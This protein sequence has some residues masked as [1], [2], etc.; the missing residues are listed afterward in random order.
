[1]GIQKL[2]LFKLLII[3]YRV[4]YITLFLLSFAIFAENVNIDCS[5]KN[6]KIEGF[7]VTTEVSNYQ[8]IVSMT[9][10]YSKSCIP[11]DEN[12]IVKYVSDDLQVSVVRVVIKPQLLSWKVEDS[13]KISYKDFKFTGDWKEYQKKSLQ[14]GVDIYKSNPKEV[15][16]IGVVYSPPFWMKEKGAIPEFFFGG[17]IDKYKNHY[18]KF[19]VEWI[20]MMKEKYGVPIYALNLHAGNHMPCGRPRHTSVYMYLNHETK[21]NHNYI[22]KLGV[23][24][25]VVGNSFKSQGIKT[26]LMGPGLDIGT[27][28]TSE[29]PALDYIEKILNKTKSKNYLKIIALHG[30]KNL[31]ISKVYNKLKEKIEKQIKVPIWI[32]QSE[33]EFAEWEELKVV[34]EE[35]AESLSFD[36][37]DDDLGGLGGLDETSDVKPVRKKTFDEVQDAKRKKELAKKVSKADSKATGTPSAFYLALKMHSSLKYLNASSYVYGYVSTQLA[38][39]KGSKMAESSALMDGEKP[40]KKSFVFKHYSKFIRPNAYRVDTTNDEKS[41]ILSSA[42]LHD[43]NKTLTVVLINKTHKAISVPVSIKGC[44]VKTMDIYQ[45]TGDKSMN[46]KKIGNLKISGGNGKIKLP[47]LSVTTLYGKI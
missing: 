21:T 2:K 42:F 33:G 44:S 11:F 9:T 3:Q 29:Q 16:I 24:Y 6:Q 14:M 37:D 32:T 22:D 28:I 31:P 18:A 20:K 36:D 25:D 7:G 41:D 43:A 8:A 12:K 34:V 35:K 27:D 10:K 39:V 45:T 17:I 5:K 40:L 19:L 15:K 4:T 13:E 46:C 38:G 23:V 47:P 30:N 1:M 26:L